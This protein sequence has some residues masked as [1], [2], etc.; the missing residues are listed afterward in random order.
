MGKPQAIS[1]TEKEKLAFNDELKTDRVAG[2]RLRHKPKSPDT[3]KSR[4]RKEE[5]EHWGRSGS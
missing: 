4:Q 3:E 5:G 1:V 2:L